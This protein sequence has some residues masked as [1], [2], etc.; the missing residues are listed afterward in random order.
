MVWILCDRQKT[1][2][3]LPA[4]VYC[5]ARRRWY[6]RW[7]SVD[8]AYDAVPLIVPLVIFYHSRLKKVKDKTVKLSA[9]FKQVFCNAGYS[10]IFTRLAGGK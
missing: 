2:L 9:F 7:A 4:T 8:A 5:A 10:G 3:R 1:V 6:I